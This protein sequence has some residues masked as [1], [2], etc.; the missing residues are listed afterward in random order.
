MKSGRDCLWGSPPRQG[1]QPAGQGQ[2]P[3][4]ASISSCGKQDEE[5]PSQ[6]GRKAPRQEAWTG[7][8][9]N[10]YC[11][12]SRIYPVPCQM[13]GFAFSTCRLVQ[14]LGGLRTAAK[15][16]FTALAR[17]I[18]ISCSCEHSAGWRCVFHPPSHC[19][20]R[21]RRDC[22]PPICLLPFAFCLLPTDH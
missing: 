10:S 14:A 12:P 17:N 5:V 7:T 15:H 22:A 13:A 1:A 18:H 20:S 9:E 4:R 2:T 3:V 11:R 8:L 16:S 21:L 19:A 6:A